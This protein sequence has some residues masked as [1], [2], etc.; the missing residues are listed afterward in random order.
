MNTVTSA[1]GT[2]IGYTRHG[3]GPRVILVGGGL[4]D[5]TEN[6]PLAEALAAHRAQPIRSQHR[7]KESNPWESSRSRREG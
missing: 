3:D 4:D 7:E 2:V 5:G 6:A 1:D